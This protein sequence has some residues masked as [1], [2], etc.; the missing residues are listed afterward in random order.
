MLN[1]QSTFAKVSTAIVLFLILA[2]MATCLMPL[3]HGAT[4]HPRPNSLGL[5]QTYQNPYVYMLG[6]IEHADVLSNATV[7]DF[8]PFGASLLDIESI[9]FCGD[10]SRELEEGDNTTLYVFTYRQQTTQMYHGIGCHDVFRIL[11]LGPAK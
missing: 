4:T 10:L 2:L 6:T 9:L 5:S 8:K 1:K 11:Q 3:A 7:V